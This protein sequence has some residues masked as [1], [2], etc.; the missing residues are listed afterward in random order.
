M[1]VLTFILLITMDNHGDMI[2]PAR[3]RTALDAY[4]TI[5]A[6]MESMGL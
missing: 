6:R 4:P 1:R 3:L 5:R 2:L